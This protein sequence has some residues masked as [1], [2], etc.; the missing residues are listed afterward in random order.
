MLNVYRFLLFPSEAPATFEVSRRFGDFEKVYKAVAPHAK[1]GGIALPK[2]PSSGFR[3]F[4]TKNKPA[5][6]N[7]RRV[8]FQQLMDVILAHPPLYNRSIVMKFLRA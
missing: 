6:V 5:V 7:E 3:T 2:F 4:F 1:A 8:A